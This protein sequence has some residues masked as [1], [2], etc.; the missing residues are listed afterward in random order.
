MPRFMRGIHPA[1]EL[2]SSSNQELLMKL[3]ISIVLCVLLVS[4]C[5]PAGSGRDY[6]PQIRAANE[7]LF[8]KG[9]VAVARDLFAADYVVH[10][11]GG[12]QRGP[13]AIEQFVTQLRA[14]FPDLRY[15]VEILATE[16]DRVAWMR[17]HQ[18]THQ[19]EFMGVPASGRIVSWR[20]IVVTRYEA[21]KIAEEWAV[22]DLGEQLRAP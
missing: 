19:A 17:T 13:E 7:E 11:N 15:D 4:A 2:T 1:A 12:E 3:Q 20:D 21:G 10:F 16:G 14:A 22:T 8:T 18:G 6:A 9:N 5:A